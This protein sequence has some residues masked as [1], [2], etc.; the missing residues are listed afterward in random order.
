M[1]SIIEENL[2]KYFNVSQNVAVLEA[3]MNM[4]TVSNK[5][6]TWED[7]IKSGRMVADVSEESAFKRADWQDERRSGRP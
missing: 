4:L 1:L 5:G 2:K 6:L 3:Q 7:E